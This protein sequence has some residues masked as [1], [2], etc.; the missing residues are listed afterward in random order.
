MNKD[1][2]R[3]YFSKFLS[4]Y[5]LRPENAFIAA[6]LAVRLSALKS[7]G[8]NLDLSCGDGTFAFTLFGGELEQPQDIF[9][10]VR[11][12]NSVLKED[13]DIYN[14]SNS[15]HKLIISKPPLN[16][17]DFGI[18]INPVMLGRAKGLGI[19]GQMIEADACKAIPL[20]SS[21][22][23]M[24]YI[25]HTINS[26]RDVNRAIS[27][28]KRILANNGVAVISIYGS[29][30]ASFYERLEKEYPP[31]LSNRIERGLREKFFRHNCN[32]DEWIGKF[33][34]AGFLIDTAIG[35]VP[36]AYTP[37]WCLGVRPIA[38]ALIELVN[39]IREA[40]PG[41]VSRFKNLWT[42]FFL[43]LGESL[44]T[45]DVNIDDAFSY[46]LVVRKR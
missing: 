4:I 26:Y 34:K 25:N 43:E 46:L 20:E 10:Q 36:A 33:E 6:T 44:Y 8:R 19:Y 35:L 39:S 38:P 23:D 28:L 12:V 2:F 27:E 40:L 15:A 7:N 29:T 3:T 21:S 41:S 45:E 16:M 42:E 13:A 18:D 17:L 9:T 1:A 14:I 11:D 30:V 5:W 22:I 37:L 24:A 31:S 32:P